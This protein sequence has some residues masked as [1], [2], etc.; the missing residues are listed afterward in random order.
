M[1]MVG[2]RIHEDFVTATS[3][4]Q[5]LNHRALDDTEQEML[6]VLRRKACQ[7]DTTCASRSHITVT[8]VDSEIMLDIA[9][10]IATPEIFSVY[11]SPEMCNY[12]RS[13]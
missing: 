12:L 6:S 1:A 7:E 8:V 3:K 5:T 9:L 2:R 10:G 4:R 13:D 11:I